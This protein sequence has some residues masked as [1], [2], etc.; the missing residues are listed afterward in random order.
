MKHYL[1]LTIKKNIDPDLAWEECSKIGIENLYLL[2]DDSGK[3]QLFGETAK[4]QSI[5]ELLSKIPTIESIEETPPPTVDWENQW[6]SFG[7]NYHD[8]YVHLDLSQ[9]S[10][11][12]SANSVVLCLKP[13]PG[14]GD[15]SHPSTLLVLEMMA[16]KTAGQ[17][18]SD[19][20]CGSGV[21]SLAAIASGA[22]SVDAIDIDR[23]AIGHA[24]ENAGI[25]HME[26]KISFYTPEEYVKQIAQNA[27]TPSLILMNMIPEEQHIAWN[28]L[29][30]LHNLPAKIIVSG[31]LEEKRESYL[32]E[33][34][35]RGW[36]P[37]E[38]RT[39]DGWIAFLIDS[40]IYKNTS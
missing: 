38:E 35:K 3:A 29:P 34:S 18:V 4:S 32:N 28:S 30:Q 1:S 26:K 12:P 11:S 33:C 31:I 15:L 7:M 40:G 20:G 39:K 22:H 27:A 5:Q 14:F 13:G 6:A 19:V 2:Q 24:Y 8:G 36:K 23:A 25:N 37:L 17:R 21:L 10:P 9:F 16:G